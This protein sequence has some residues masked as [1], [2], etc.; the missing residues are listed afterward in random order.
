[1]YTAS[2][3]DKNDSAVASKREKSRHIYWSR[4]QRLDEPLRDENISDEEVRQVEAVTDEIYP[5]A[6]VNISGV[7]SG[8]P[9]EDGPSCTSQVWVV[10][11]RDGR[12]DGLMLS[13]IDDDW[14]VG[15]LQQWWLAWDK[16]Q[17]RKRAT[18]STREPGY[19]ENY[20]K[21]REEQQKLQDA[22]PTCAPE[23]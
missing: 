3:E 7:T 12:N 20:L 14:V 11:Y 6:I 23:V 18:L 1:M 22:Y 13:K 17:S 21:L 19:R 4:P 15:P 5:G 16:L 9:C 8:C 10:A 2:S